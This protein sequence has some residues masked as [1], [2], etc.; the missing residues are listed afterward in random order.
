MAAA[1]SLGLE[2]FDNSLIKYWLIYDFGG[3]SLKVSII[4]FENN[5]IR[6]LNYK[7]DQF[8]G[9]QEI[10]RRVMNYL[11]DEYKMRYQHN[12]D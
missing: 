4:K 11:L 12:Y 1:L 5:R 2:N 8:I 7:D 3:S 9:G 6:L 10:D